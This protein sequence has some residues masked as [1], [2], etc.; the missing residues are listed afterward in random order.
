M[1][2]AIPQD[3]VIFQKKWNVNYFISSLIKSFFNKVNLRLIFVA[4][5]DQSGKEFLVSPTLTATEI[6]LFVYENWPAGKYFYSLIY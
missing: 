5:G 3:K 6:A 4:G 2:K 1:N